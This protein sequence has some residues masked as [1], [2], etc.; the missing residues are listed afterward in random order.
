MIDTIRLQIP[1]SEAQ[2]LCIT[3]SALAEDR[4]Q[5]VKF[6]P[7]S[8]DLKLVR[9]NSRFP[10]DQNSYHREIRWD[11]NHDWQPGKTFLTVELSLPKFWYGDNIRLLHEPAKALNLLSRYLN[12]AFNLKTRRQLPPI[13]VWEVSRLDVCYTWFLA[14]QQSAQAFLDSLK[15]QKFPYKEATKRPTSITFTG[16]DHATYSAK[17]YLKLPE[18][19]KHDAKALKKAR[20][21][22]GEI[23]FREKLA[24]AIL[25]FEVTL[26][27]QW[28]KRNG[29]R[30]IADII[31]PSYEFTFDAELV[32]KLTPFFNPKIT[33]SCVMSRYVQGK[34]IDVYKNIME[35]RTTPFKD[36]QYFSAP[37][38]TYACDGLIY[39][40]PGGGFTVSVSLNKPEEI[41]KQM[42]YKVVGQ[43]G[44][45]NLPDRVKQKVLEHYKPI[46]AANLTAFWLYVQKFGAD[47]AKEV[48]G[49]RTFYYR[50]SELK[51]AGVSLLEG[52]ENTIILGKDF[53]TD[54]AL[55]IPSEHVGNK[56]DDER[57]SLNIINLISRLEHG[58]KQDIG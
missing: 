15:Q 28:L 7:R 43:Q 21:P 11:A 40:H 12:Q 8:G 2:H 23:R 45:M 41:L 20:M 57:D 18:W 54:F 46:K 34:G 32:E 56:E 26:R 39:N 13:D 6:N 5:W 55:T 24:E 48:Y 10:T 14:N 17:F 37:E 16:G 49:S 4:D 38:G 9:V 33:I 25:R 52:K 27:P 30:T 35:G 47:S 58:G 31:H 50:K 51:K 22:E 1:L 19:L 3:N 42:L 53:F 36:G 29:I 44:T